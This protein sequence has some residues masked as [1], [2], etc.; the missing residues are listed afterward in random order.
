MPKAG[1]PEEPAP[2]IAFAGSVDVGAPLIASV[3]AAAAFALRS[4]GLP[5]GHHGLTGPAFV[6]E[7]EPGV[8][9]G[10]LAAG[11]TSFGGGASYHVHAVA[12]RTWNEP[13][14]ARD[15]TTYAGVEFGA[16]AL[17]LR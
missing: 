9:G 6:L 13:V 1:W 5:A 11:F 7:L 17:A 3:S 4:D 15:D 14:F 12:L 10:K 16:R 2:R 8:A